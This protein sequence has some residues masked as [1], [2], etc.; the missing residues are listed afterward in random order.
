MSYQ[1]GHKFTKWKKATVKGA[2]DSKVGLQRWRKF[3]YNQDNK[4][5]EININSFSRDLYKSK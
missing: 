1:S 5:S 4:D 2:F 3:L